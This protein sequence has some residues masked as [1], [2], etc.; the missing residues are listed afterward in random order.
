MKSFAQEWGGLSIMAIVFAMLAA[1]FVC[2]PHVYAGLNQALVAN[3]SSNGGIAA[4]SSGKE[5]WEL[6]NQSVPG[7]QPLPRR[8]H[9]AQRENL[10]PQAGGVSRDTLSK[11]SLSIIVYNSTTS[12][13]TSMSWT[14]DGTAIDIYE[15]WAGTG[16]AFLIFDGLQLP[17][18]D[19]TVRVHIINST[20][21]DWN[22][23][24]NELL[25][26]AGQYE[27]VQYDQP[28]EPWV[29]AGFS[30]SNDMDG[31]SFAQGSG[32]PRTSTSFHSLLTDESATRD[33][34][35]FY[36][37]LVPAQS[38][39]ELQTFGLRD[40]AN[41]DNQ[42][43]LLMQ[44]PNKQSLPSV[45]I[46]KICLRPTVDGGRLTVCPTVN[47][48][49]VGPAIVDNMITAV[50]TNYCSPIPDERSDIYFHF[51]W[52]SCTN[53]DFWDF[54]V[55]NHAGLKWSFEPNLSPWLIDILISRGTEA[56]SLALAS[57]SDSTGII[58]DVH[59]FVNLAQWLARPQPLQPK[60]TIS[61]GTCPE[62][63]GYIIGTT[64]MVFDSLAGPEENPMRTTPL[65]GTLWLDAT[66]GVTLVAVSRG[67]ANG[68]GTVDISDVVYLIAYIFS[69]GS[70]PSQ[71]LAGDANCDAA[72]DI[73]DVVYLIAYIFSG[74][75]A[76]CAG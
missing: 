30:C 38:D 56:D 72:V 64:P 36:D 65:N 68:D 41:A 9:D 57:L 34:V 74:G 2:P 3:W 35:K 60:Y 55:V 44:G 32:I 4:D 24:S 22:L 71:L 14:I 49:I 39:Q 18:V 52:Q 6:S 26:P 69:G 45:V 16:R 66:V 12:L 8:Q 33:Y 37:G 29:P 42:P 67:D 63:P 58:K 17:G 47:G 11:R 61:N 27:D 28:S 54:G 23:F 50:G 46:P 51:Y 40:N 20:S 73:S 31:L 1:V 25:D 43:F 19:Y 53:S 15:T 70:A 76:P 13:I 75:A 48:S 21:I 5:G 7:D 62:L 10:I 59:V